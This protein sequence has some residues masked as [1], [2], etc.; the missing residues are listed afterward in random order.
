MPRLSSRSRRS[1]RIMPPGRLVASGYGGRSAGEGEA[2]LGEG[3]EPFDGGADGPSH[4]QPMIGAVNDQRLCPNRF[5][6]FRVSAGIVVTICRTGDEK[7]PPPFVYNTVTG[8]VE[9]EQRRDP[10][11]INV[12]GERH[13]SHCGQEERPA[14]LSNEGH[15][16]RVS[17]CQDFDD[18]LGDEGVEL[19]G[20]PLARGRGAETQGR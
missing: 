1:R 6:H 20:V 16:G 13:L 10:D 19:N 18:T 5:A 12:S 17:L 8:V 14:R 7:R 9:P 4:D 15:P 11:G 3:S 2:R